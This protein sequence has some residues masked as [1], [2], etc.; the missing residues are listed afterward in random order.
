MTQSS[1]SVRIIDAQFVMGSADPMGL[2]EITIPEVAF[3]G[4]T[5]VGKSTL[6]NR[7]TGRR[8]LARSSGTPGRT[9]EFNL[10]KAQ[11]MDGTSRHQ[12]MLVDLPGFGYSQF[13]KKKRVI[14]EKA[15]VTYL[16]KRRSLSAV[17]VLNDVRRNPE[18]EE[19]EVISMAQERDIPVLVVVTKGD[20]LNV[21]DLTRRQR[22]LEAR[23]DEGIPLC[24]TG[25][26]SDPSAIIAHLVQLLNRATP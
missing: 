22:E 10:F 7:L 6:I 9:Q 5:N 12:M 8:S 25:S 13:S 17:C 21:R 20:K 15:T 24:L 18:E 11:I 3:I 14:L 2:P 19:L 16:M 26:S 23:F 1:S 4:R